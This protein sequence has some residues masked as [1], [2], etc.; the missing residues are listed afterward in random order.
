MERLRKLKSW[1]T[2]KRVLHKMQGEP[3]VGI[4]TCFFDKLGI[5]KHKACLFQ[6]LF[7]LNQGSQ[8]ILPHCMILLLLLFYNE[9]GQ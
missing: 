9:E 1:F 3:V 4:G 5:H 7:P 8:S 2:I 6:F